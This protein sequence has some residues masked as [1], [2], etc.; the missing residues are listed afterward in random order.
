MSFWSDPWTNNVL[1]RSF[2]DAPDMT[3]FNNKFKLKQEKKFK[4]IRQLMPLQFN[5]QKPNAENILYSVFSYADPLPFASRLFDLIQYLLDIYRHRYLHFVCKSMF[6]LMQ[7]IIIVSLSPSEQPISH[8]MFNWCGLACSLH[9]S[10]LHE[11]WH[12]NW[13]AFFHVVGNKA[14]NREITRDLVNK[15]SIFQ[16]RWTK[17][18]D[19][20]IFE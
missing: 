7:S 20:I 5:A 10:Y 4:N 14:K 17:C 8:F 3:N 19:Q 13:L 12:V 9:V 18:T 15:D 16:R 6:L 2:D 1:A 11:Q